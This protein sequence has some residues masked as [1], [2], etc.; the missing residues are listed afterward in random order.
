MAAGAPLHERVLYSLPLNYLHGSYYPSHFRP[1]YLP[2][3]LETAAPKQMLSIS[4]PDSPKQEKQDN[5]A[6]VSLQEIKLILGIPA[7]P[8][9]S[10]M[11]INVKIDSSPFGPVVSVSNPTTITSSPTPDDAIIVDVGVDGGNISLTNK[12]TAYLI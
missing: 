10:S 3:P 6:T 7:L 8:E 11:S 5:A 2:I 12:Q 1:T 9:G 4:K